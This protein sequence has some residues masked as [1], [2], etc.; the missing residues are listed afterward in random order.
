MAAI[1]T[2]TA[3]AAGIIMFLTRI[4]TTP[5]ATPRCASR[6]A[7]IMVAGDMAAAAI[8]G[9]KVPAAASAGV[10]AEWARAATER[11][12]NEA[13]SPSAFLFHLFEGRR[14]F[15]EILEHRLRV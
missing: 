12:P 10:A 2:V 5:T 4:R 15:R 8:A 6:I 14:G 3:I 9:G 1:A 7:M 13:L 11:S